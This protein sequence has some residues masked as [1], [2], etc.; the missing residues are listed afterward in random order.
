MFTS[1]YDEVTLNG[2]D[3]TEFSISNAIRIRRYTK[4]LAEDLMPLEHRDRV[5]AGQQALQKLRQ[6]WAERGYQV[7]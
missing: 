2:Y 7:P 5:L 4:A 3:A 1:V 6:I